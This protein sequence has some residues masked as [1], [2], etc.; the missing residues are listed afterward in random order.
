MQSLPDVASLAHH[1]VV[2]LIGLGREAERR[3]GFSKLVRTDR[4]E[5]LDDRRAK[6]GGRYGICHVTS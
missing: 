1:R 4:V 6:V 3:A 2:V 5:R